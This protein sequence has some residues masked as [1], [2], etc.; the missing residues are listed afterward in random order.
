VV[1][2]EVADAAD[3]CESAAL[4]DEP[5]AAADEESPYVVAAHPFEPTDESVLVAVPA[6]VVDGVVLPPT[7][8]VVGAVESAMVPPRP[9]NAATLPAAAIVRSRRAE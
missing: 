2:D 6:P 1:A 7:V 5:D 3:C 4:V 9:T 8:S